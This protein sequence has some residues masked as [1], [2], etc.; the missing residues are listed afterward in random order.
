MLALFDGPELSIV[1]LRRSARGEV[2]R[3]VP[4]GA[5][6]KHRP[7]EGGMAFPKPRFGRGGHRHE[8]NCSA[9]LNDTKACEDDV[10]TRQ[11]KC[12]S[13]KLQAELTSDLWQVEITMRGNAQ[14]PPSYKAG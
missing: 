6:E 3:P 10:T 14:V 1:A 7:H 5:P 4:G 13:I 2:H 9:A 12:V 11:L 8:Y